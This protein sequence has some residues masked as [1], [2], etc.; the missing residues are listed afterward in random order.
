MTENLLFSMIGNQV[1]TKTKHPWHYISIKRGHGVLVMYKKSAV[2]KL[3]QFKSEFVKFVKYEHVKGEND[4]VAVKI[5]GEF[6]EITERELQRELERK[7]NEIIIGGWY[8]S[9][10]DGVAYVDV[11][12]E[13]AVERVEALEYIRVKIDTTMWSLLSSKQMTPT[14]GVLQRPLSKD[15]QEEVSRRT[16][17]RRYETER[18]KE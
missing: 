17:K 2:A 13:K 12:S 5:T 10:K 9:M 6:G 16:G 7:V 8:A 15:F 14:S 11:Q 18:K 4:Y 1:S 3:L